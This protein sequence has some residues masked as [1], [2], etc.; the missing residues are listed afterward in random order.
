[1]HKE[2]DIMYIFQ[3]N[4]ICGIMLINMDKRQRFAIQNKNSIGEF[5]SRI[6]ANHKEESYVNNRSTGNERYIA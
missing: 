4:K 3:K 5:F 1:M 6:I 2:Y